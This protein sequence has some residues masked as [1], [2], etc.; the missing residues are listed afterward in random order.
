MSPYP[1]T[2]RL[3]DPPLHEFMNLT[4]KQLKEIANDLSLSI[5]KVKNR[6]DSLHETNPMLG[7]RGCRLGIAYPEITI[8]QTRAIFEASAELIKSKI[9]VFPEIMIPLVGSFK[10]FNHQKKIINN[11]ANEIQNNH[12]IKIKYLVG[13]MIELPRACMTADE[14]ANTADFF[15]F[16]TN[17]LT[18]MTYGYSRDDVNTFLPLY[19][20]NDIIS[21]DPFQTIDKTGVGKL[22]IEGIKKGRKIK[23]QIKIGICGEHGG[24]PKSVMFFNKVGL[25]YV[26]CSPYRIPIAKLAAAQAMLEEE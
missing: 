7:H 16:G 2:I 24:D 12:N 20:K 13:T 6:I 15:S 1:V 3:L 26:S 19:I 21:K 25:D 10:E 9:K 8:M 22:I 17:D 4:E 11:I 23:P 5:K 18:Q 14:I